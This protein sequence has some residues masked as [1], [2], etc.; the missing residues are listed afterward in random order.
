MLPIDEIVKALETRAART[1]FADLFLRAQTELP[2]SQRVL[3]E[4][5]VRSASDRDA[6]AEALRYAEAHGFLD[7]LLTAVVAAGLEDGTLAQAFAEK[8]IN[9]RT[10][11]ARL[12]AMANAVRRFQQPHVMYRGIANGMRWTGKV[13]IDGQPRGTGILIGANLL[14]T[15][16]HVVEPLFE[17]DT[18]LAYRPKPDGAA[19]L[20]LQ[21]DDF[22]ELVGRRH[23][24]QPAVA[25]LVKAHDEWCVVYSVCHQDELASRLPADLTALEGHWDYAVLRLAEAPGLE[26]RWSPLDARAVVPAAKNRIVVFQHP[27]GQ[28]L[29]VDSDE[30]V[31]VEPSQTTVFPRLR[32]LH[33]A[34]SGK[35]SS[36]GPCFDR[37]FMLFGLHQGEW[38]RNAAAADGDEAGNGDGAI[39]RGIPI[40]RVIEH[41]KREIK[42][43]PLPDPTEIPVWRLGA[44]DGYAP[45]LG[46]QEFQT[47]VWH[48]AIGGKPRLLVIS[49]PRGTGKTH[50]VRLLSSMLPE[51]SHLKIVLRAESISKMDAAALGALICSEAG[52]VAPPLASSS[53]LNSTPAVWLKTEVLPKLL[54]ALDQARNGRLVWLLVTDL[55]LF[56][57]Q[58]DHARPLLL[59]LYEQT[60]TLDWLRIVLDGMR[61]DIP[62]SL[63]EVLD[64]QRTREI[65]R[66]EIE[67]YLRRLTAEME[68][69]LDDF[70]IR[71]N[72]RMLFT[73]Y[74]R[75]LTLDPETAAQ[76]LAD[77]VMQLAQAYMAEGQ[78]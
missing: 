3:F 24:F 16:W 66:E 41:F 22:L 64:R 25:R 14:L 9:E 31:K 33:R 59:L 37:E 11:D 49:G 23:A 2:L 46:C 50:R 70:T 58:G 51:V 60:L 48:S 76:H 75:A 4:A 13:L 61:G 69:P 28:A 67:T 17:L 8:A 47:A 72:S 21:F 44:S 40:V 12:Q 71:A 55:D 19:R 45:V 63:N 18:A 57:I 62:S 38:R 42:D 35:G 15:A 20:H 39:N 30:I 36:G 5:V 1:D 27:G 73:N 68:L 56:E 65:T 26:R 54:T 7:A 29:R 74:D 32:F 53:E 43:L 10:D 78:G 52:S 77:E 6:F 34:N